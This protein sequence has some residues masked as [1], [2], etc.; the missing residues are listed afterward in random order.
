M[1]P[2]QTLQNAPVKSLEVESVPEPNDLVDEF[3]AEVRDSFQSWAALVDSVEALVTAEPYEPPVIARRVTLDAFLRL[4]IAWESFRSD[5]YISAVCSDSSRFQTVVGE[6]LS[7]AIA[8]TGYRAATEFMQIA[9]PRPLSPDSIRDL[10]DSDGFNLTFR[11]ARSWQDRAQL[12]LPSTYVK[13]VLN[14]SGQDLKFL[15]FLIAARNWLVHG[16][17]RSQALFAAAAAP[18]VLIFATPLEAAHPAQFAEWLLQRSGKGTIF[19]DCCVRLEAVAEV[20][21]LPNATN[22]HHE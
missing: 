22:T 4:G 15:D 20:L 11:S 18:L 2:T 1:Q 6:T 13:H 16:S 3:Q 19:E 12:E 9:W 10:L 21:R 17:R 5:W 14:L 7:R 8:A